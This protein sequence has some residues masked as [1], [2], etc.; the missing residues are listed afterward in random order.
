M[1]YSKLWSNLPRSSLLECELH[2]RWTF[3]VML[4]LKDS[5]GIVFG[6]RTALARA[7]NLSLEQTSNAL[8]VLSSP[9]PNSSSKRDEGRRLREIAPNR[10]LVVNADDYRGK[11][12]DTDPLEKG[13]QR[14][15]R[16]RKRKA[17]T[18][19]A[20][21]ANG[22]ETVTPVTGASQASHGDGDADAEQ[23]RAEANAKHSRAERKTAGGEVVYSA[24]FVTFWKAYPKRVGKGK[25]SEEW[26]K[27]KAPRPDLD[28][29]LAA[30]TTQKRSKAW[31]KEDGQY[32]PNPSRW[33]NERRW[34]DEAARRS[35]RDYMGVSRKVEV[36][37][38]ETGG[39]AS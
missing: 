17:L 24:D 20:G 1:G 33:I 21:D 7:V 16:W 32:I 11:R 25:A 34:E 38:P 28:Q 10:W 37:G 4:A 5:D 15:R 18:Q 36:D 35:T 19:P 29:V 13:R 12:D 30:I 9:D 23:C 39:G 22:A 2:V 31:R 26:Q 3:V 6:T 8:D 14:T 27:I